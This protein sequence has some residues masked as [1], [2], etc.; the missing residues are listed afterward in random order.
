VSIVIHPE[1]AEMIYGKLISILHHNRFPYNLPAAIV[2]QDPCNLPRRMA[3]GGAEEAVFLFCLCYYMRGGIKSVTAARSLSQM[4]DYLKDWHPNPFIM[5]EAAEIRPETITSFLRK[6]GLGFQSQQIGQFWT[7]NARRLTTLWNGDPRKIFV[8][9]D[10]YQ[11][12][13]KRVQNNKKGAGF[14]GFQ[15]K[16]VSMLLYYL[17]DEELIDFFYFPIPIDM[18]VMRIHVANEIITFDKEPPSDVMSQDLLVALRQ[19]TISYA[20][21][22]GV[23]PLRLCDA[24]W[25]LSSTLCEQNPG[26]GT[27][28]GRYQARST[29]LTPKALTWSLTQIEAFDRSCRSCP[30]R[31]TCKWDVPSGPYY[32]RGQLIK[33][34]PRTE[35]PVQSLFPRT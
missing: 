11:E 6:F 18:H 35:P 3:L 21:Q 15:E 32:R 5:A 28:S 33:L 22:E 16:M 8:E 31:D 17:M 2:P 10:S 34:R 7:E 30:L 19:L 24:L 14:L 27:H 12:A 20:R 1:K 23:N 29:Y 9:V 26:N 25:L 13:L 4:Y